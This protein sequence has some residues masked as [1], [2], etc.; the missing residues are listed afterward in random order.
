MFIPDYQN[1]VNAAENKPSSRI[2]VYEHII[3]PKIME[4]M[5]GKKF[6]QLLEGNY[7][8]KQEFFRNYSGFF[9]D[10]GYDAVS[11]EL[12]VPQVMPGSGALRDN[13]E[14]AIKNRADFDA[15]PWDAIPDFFFEKYREFYRAFGETMPPGMKGIGGVG[16][17]VFEIVQDLVGFQE[18]CY[19]KVDDEDLYA[20]LFSKVGGLLANIWDR[21]LKEFADI[22]CVCR[23]GDDLGFKSSTLISAEDIRLHIIPQYRRLAD[24][25][26]A[27][28]KPMLFHSCGYLFDV[29]DDIISGS[30]IDA[31]HSNEDVIAPYSRWID[32]YG[33]K[34]GNFGGLDTDVLCASSSVD[35]V[36]YTTDIYRL[37]E[38]KGRGV[39]IGSGNSIPDYVD[40]ARYGQAID[41]IRRLRGE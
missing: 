25:A 35:V 30:K 32:D 21:F 26:H 3:A 16:Y 24:L 1:I 20:A 18:L 34:I 8:D 15:Y 19:I 13:A 36:A 7:S 40:P 37:C 23:F 11:F 29:M 9:K 31:K 12:G 10:Y 5:Q 22:F 33:D 14:G 6:E 2:P 17:G 4:T 28:G 41:T 38:K 27:H 39:A